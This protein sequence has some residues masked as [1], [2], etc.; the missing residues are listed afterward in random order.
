[1]SEPSATAREQARNIV[2]L[3]R[4]GDEE[5]DAGLAQDI[6]RALAEKDAEFDRLRDLR[7]EAI[8]E[9]SEWAR[10]VEGLRITLAAMRAA[11]IGLAISIPKD[12]NPERYSWCDDGS[13]CDHNECKAARAAI[14]RTA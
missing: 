10:E 1:M 5:N 3:W 6:A 8:A 4:I 9:S 2:L 13:F 11:L 14:A 12:G 7:D